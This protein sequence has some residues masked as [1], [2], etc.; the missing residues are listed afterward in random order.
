M[1]KEQIK[2]F[3]CSQC[4]GGKFGR[5]SHICKDIQELQ[6]KKRQIAIILSKKI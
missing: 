2:P 1:V 4:G 3:K 5:Q 6:N